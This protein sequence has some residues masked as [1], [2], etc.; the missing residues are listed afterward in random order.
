[1]KEETRSKE[2]P[3]KKC[4]SQI[5][6]YVWVTSNGKLKNV[7]RERLRKH[8]LNKF[9]KNPIEK[10]LYIYKKLKLF[11]AEKKLKSILIV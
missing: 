9:V 11:F 2:K 6:K 4:I 1:M 7:Y 8:L 5:I 3:R 10:K